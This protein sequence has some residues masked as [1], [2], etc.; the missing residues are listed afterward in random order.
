MHLRY[1]AVENIVKKAEI[2]CNKQISP[3]LTMFSTLYGN[4]FSFQMHF[5]TSSAICFNLDQ[6]KTRTSTKYQGLSA[7]VL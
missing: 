7:K 1:I 2:A 5:K 4:H 3:F 6:S